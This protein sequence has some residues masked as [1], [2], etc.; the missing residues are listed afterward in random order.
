MKRKITWIRHGQS[1]WNAQGIWQ[2]HTDVPLSELGRDQAAALGRRLGSQRFDA[3]YSS[4]LARSR[5]TCELALPDA[6]MVLDERLREINF[7]VYEGKSRE[8]LTTEEAAAVKT[9]WVEPYV[10]K[11]Q[12]GESMTCLNIRVSEFLAELPSECEV[13]IFTHGG[14]IRNALW[15]VVGVPVQGAWSVQIEN[16]SVTVLEYTSERTLV[17]RVNDSAHLEI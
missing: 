10:E 15:Q 7:G 11:L 12:G 16:T 17:H 4:D 8:T 6:E 9:W 3:V 1:T 13:A 2:G 5:Q 14:V